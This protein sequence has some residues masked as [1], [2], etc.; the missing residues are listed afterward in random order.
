MFETSNP[1]QP[2][3]I[4][5]RV[6]VFPQDLQVL[7]KLYQ[8]LIG[9]SGVALY[10]TLMADY[11]AAA[12]LS[13]S[14]GIYHLQEQLDCSLK[15]LFQALHKLEAVGLVKT[16]IIKNEIMGQV[17]LFSLNRVPGSSEFFATALLA[18]LLKEKVGVTTFQRLSHLF[19]QENKRSENQINGVQTAKDVSASFMDVFRLPDEEAISPSFDVQQAAQENQVK[20]AATASVNEQDQIDWQFM[21]E[22]FEIYQIAASEIDKNRPAIRGIMRT[23]GLSEQ[24]FVDETLPCLHDSYQLDMPLIKR[25]IAENI[26]AEGTRKNLQQT[27]DP[28]ATIQDNSSLSLRDQRILQ[29][30]QTKSPAQFLYRLKTDKHDYVDASEYKVLDNLYNQKDI[31]AELLNILTYACLNSGPSVSY[32]LANTILH[33]WLQ[34]GVKT[35]SQALE[36]M[37]KRQQKKSYYP[38]YSTKPKRVEKGTDWSKK[39]A[40]QSTDVSSA[41]LKKFFKDLED[42]NGMK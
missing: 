21:K 12:I 13:D 33:D 3:F 9:A 38:R 16:R 34:H 10:L 22:Q 30:A 4:I 40:T 31:P 35:G 19:A 6:T 20:Q 8:P 24:E 36:Y 37:E 23:Y 1:K 14:K 17:L 28:Q 5:N 29:L 11:D 15:E 41:D 18:S 42:K 27:Q 7:I 25:T 26:H 32:R 2:F 39:T